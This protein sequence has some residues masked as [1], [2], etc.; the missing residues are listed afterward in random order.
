MTPFWFSHDDAKLRRIK[1]WVTSLAARTRRSP[2]NLSPPLMSVPHTTIRSQYFP[3]Q[4]LIMRESLANVFVNDQAM[5][6]CA[7]ERSLPRARLARLRTATAR[8]SARARAAHE[9]ASPDGLAALSEPLPTTTCPSHAAPL[10]SYTITFANDLE[11]FS[12]LL[13]AQLKSPTLHAQLDEVDLPPAADS[14]ALAVPARDP[15]SAH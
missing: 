5:S 4:H 11:A 10:S 12:S 6:L 15:R 1:S 9:R 7:L 14:P 13:Q 3:E 8:N 2:A